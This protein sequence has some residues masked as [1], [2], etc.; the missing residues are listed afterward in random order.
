[1]DQKTVTSNQISTSQWA[2]RLSHQTKYL[3]HNGPKDCHIKPNIYISM[4]QKT[5]TSNQMSTSQWAKRLSHQTKYLHPN[6]P[7][8]CHIKPNIYIPMGQKTSPRC[9][10][11]VLSRQKHILRRCF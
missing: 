9:L 7:K 11:T 8:D 6:G 3:H 4:G 1:M 5:V 2:K 10:M